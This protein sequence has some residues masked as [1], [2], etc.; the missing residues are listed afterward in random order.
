M[1]E[2]DLLIDLRSLA[3]VK[4][5]CKLSVN[6][7]YIS[8]Q[9]PTAGLWMLRSLRGDNRRKTIDKLKKIVE[10][11]IEFCQN[12]VEYLLIA[13]ALNGSP[14]RDFDV[15]SKCRERFSRL[16]I[17][18]HA[19][20]EALQGIQ[21]LEA[22]YTQTVAAQISVRVIKMEKQ[23]AQNDKHLEH[24]RRVYGSAATESS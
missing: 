13:V 3:S 1:S 22:T 2:D 12:H 18:N 24:F 21:H 8:L 11:C 23:I 17:L 19:M 7:E 16:E 6:E 20:R 10:Y 5:D 15:G 14:V 9:P 4:A